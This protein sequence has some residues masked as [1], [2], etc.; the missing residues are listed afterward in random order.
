VGSTF[1]KGTSGDKKR[2]MEYRNPRVEL[3]TRKGDREGTVLAQTRVVTGGEG[4]S[5]QEFRGYK[6]REK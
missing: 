5:S 3:L 4:G 2:E 1:K 6:K